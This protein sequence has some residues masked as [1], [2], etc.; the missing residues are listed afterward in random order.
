ML[1]HAADACAK[2]AFDET[3]SLLFACSSR[4]FFCTKNWQCNF[5]F[6]FSFDIELNFVLT[7]EA[8][9]VNLAMVSSICAGNRNCGVHLL[10]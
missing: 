5:L 1:A 7:P 10:T 8:R 3:M 9:A 6:K 2:M 4:G